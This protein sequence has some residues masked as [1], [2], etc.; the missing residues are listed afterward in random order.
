[1][2]LGFSDYGVSFFGILLVYFYLSLIADAD[3]VSTG[4]AKTNVEICRH[5]LLRGIISRK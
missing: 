4:L 3:R 5:C 1:M 2:E